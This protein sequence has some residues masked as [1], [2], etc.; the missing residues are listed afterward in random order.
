MG[1]IKQPVLDIW[2]KSL[3]NDQ[4]YLF[5]NSRSLEIP[6]LILESLEDVNIFITW[7][8]S[9]LSISLAAL[10]LLLPLTSSGC[11]TS[12]VR[13][14]WNNSCLF[15]L[16]TS[17]FIKFKWLITALFAFASFSRYHSC[18]MQLFW[19][20]ESFFLDDLSRIKGELRLAE[21]GIRKITLISTYTAIFSS[22]HA[23]SKQW[24][25]KQFPKL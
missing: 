7:M 15:E 12:V 9:Y 4:Y 10:A 19:N 1:S 24:L 6:G 22:I 3:L 8:T 16:W 23:V 25:S 5:F 11:K 18:R 14:H 13:I 2:K 17:F 21:T 20:A